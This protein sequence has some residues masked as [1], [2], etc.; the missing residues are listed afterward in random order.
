MA[1]V[2]VTEAAEVM[3]EVAMVAADTVVVEDA[4]AAA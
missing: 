4:G 3:V 2:V 1:A